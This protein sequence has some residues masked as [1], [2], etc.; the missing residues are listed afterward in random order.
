MWIR[1]ALRDFR[2]AVDSPMPT[3]T[4]SNE[5]FIPR[6][7]RSHSNVS[8]ILIGEM[9]ARVRRVGHRSRTFHGEH[10]GS[11]RRASWRRTVF[12]SKIWDVDEIETWE[13][14]RQQKSFRRAN[15]SSSISSRTSLTV[16]HWRLSQCRVCEEHG[17][18]LKNDAK[19][20]VFETSSRRCFWIAR[21]D[22][23]FPGVPAASCCATQTTKCWSTWSA[24]RVFGK[25]PA[26]LVNVESRKEI[27]EMAGSQ[28]ALNHGNLAPIITGT[29]LQTR[30]IKRV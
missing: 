21:H 5:E 30:W 22:V 16:C 11:A 9:S 14:E 3:Q 26:E 25:D 24:L 4:V 15:T 1:K 17:F 20:M 19:P 28:R 2:K 13:Q 29:R 27:N 10:D 23:V 7:S 18:Q 6:R 8:N 12:A